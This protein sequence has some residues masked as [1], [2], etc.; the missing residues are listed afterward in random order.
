MFRLLTFCWLQIAGF[1]LVALL[2]GCSKESSAPPAKP[3]P[4]EVATSPRGPQ[5]MAKGPVSPTVIA[6]NAD[7]NQVLQQLTQALRDYVVRT[8][9]IPKDFEEFAAKSQVSFPAPP[10]GSKYAIKGQQVVMVKR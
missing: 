9:S 2:T 6:E 3:P 5:E 4:G 7:T 1:C 10:S 8:R